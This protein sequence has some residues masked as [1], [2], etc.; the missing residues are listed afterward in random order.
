MTLADVI[1]EAKKAHVIKTFQESG[2]NITETA[3]RLNISRKHASEMLNEWGLS[4]ANPPERIVR[5]WVVT[6]PSGGGVLEYVMFDKK[7]RHY[8]FYNKAVHETL[9]IR[10]EKMDLLLRGGKFVLK[11]KEDARVFN[12]DGLAREIESVGV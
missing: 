8:V 3:T 10:K 9:T 4:S 11:V 1:A 5:E 6:T 2:G 7:A 12:T